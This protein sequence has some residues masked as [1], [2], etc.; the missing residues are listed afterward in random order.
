MTM[1]EIL[2]NTLPVDVEDREIFLSLKSFLEGLEKAFDQKDINKISRRFGLF[3]LRHLGYP[4]P[5]SP[6]TDPLSSYFEAIMNRKII[7]KDIK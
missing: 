3:I 6:D 5:K 7:S 2:T 4:P 1:A